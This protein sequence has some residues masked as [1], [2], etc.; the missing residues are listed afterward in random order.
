[1]AREAVMEVYRDR[2][3]AKRHRRKVTPKQRRL[4][5]VAARLAKLSGGVLTL[6]HNASEHFVDDPESKGNLVCG[7]YFA[8]NGEDSISL[9]DRKGDLR[10]Q[11]VME[12]HRIAKV[13]LDLADTIEGAK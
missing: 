7:F 11:L 10:G 8:N 5:N 3:T 9:D 2:E 1:M 6:R 4:S 13:Y 12:L